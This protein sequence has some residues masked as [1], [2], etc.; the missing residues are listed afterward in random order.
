LKLPGVTISR[1][2]RS[3]GAQ[4]TTE[5]KH[6]KGDRLQTAIICPI[7]KKGSKLECKIYRGI[8]LLNVTY[9]IFI[10]ILSKYI[11]LYTDEIIGEY[12]G[13]FRKS[14]ST[15]DHIFTLRQILEKEHE[16]N[17][18]SHQLYIDFKQ[19]FDSIDRIEIIEIMREF[20]IPLKLVKLTKMTLSRTY[21]RVKIQNKLSG[22]FSTECG[23]RQGDSLS[24]LLFNIGLEKVI[25]NI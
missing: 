11:E 22:R 25:R 19:A 14:R 1:G 9:K 4:Q 23:V 2:S 16:Y 24:T 21:N 20:G 3:T 7:Y 15:T 5:I 10:N 13:G 6:K 18:S 12:R 8:S 17:I